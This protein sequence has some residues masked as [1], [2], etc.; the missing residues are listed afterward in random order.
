MNNSKSIQREIQRL[1]FR[2]TIARYDLHEHIVMGVPVAQCSELCK[3]IA[4]CQLQKRA[5]ENGKYEL[6][7]YPI[8]WLYI[9]DKKPIPR[10]SLI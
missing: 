8:R 7:P 3:E 4:I 2:I 6:L 5:L 10:A 1:S 9:R